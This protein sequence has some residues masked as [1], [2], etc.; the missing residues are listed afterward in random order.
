MTA[1]RGRISSPFRACLSQDLTSLHFALATLSVIVLAKPICEVWECVGRM[2]L[3]GRG[4]LMF[5]TL[6]ETHI[7]VKR[8]QDP[9]DNQSKPW[10][11]S[12]PRPSCRRRPA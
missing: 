9:R 3:S 1:S 6:T 10:S 12:W 5:L 4:R 8:H 7:D 11:P 2:R